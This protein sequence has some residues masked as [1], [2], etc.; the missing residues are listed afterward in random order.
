MRERGRDEQRGYECRDRIYMRDG[1]NS[2][3]ERESGRCTLT[4]SKP[5][6]TFSKETATSE[7]AP[8]YEPSDG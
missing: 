2:D 3:G 6:L 7:R 1:Q 5:F 8:E 4:D